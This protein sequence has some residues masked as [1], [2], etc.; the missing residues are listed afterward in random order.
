V[1]L[2][3]MGGYNSSPSARHFI[4]PYR[5]PAHILSTTKNRVWVT[6]SSESFTPFVLVTLVVLKTMSITHW[7]I[8]QS[9]VQMHEFHVLFSY[10]LFCNVYSK[11]S[12]ILALQGEVITTIT[13]ILTTCCCLKSTTCWWRKVVV[14]SYAIKEHKVAVRDTVYDSAF[15]QT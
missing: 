11:F 6:F 8:F 7:K 15:K 2:I 4:R 1:H 10:I 3:C 9:A 12:V 14:L 5:P 13:K